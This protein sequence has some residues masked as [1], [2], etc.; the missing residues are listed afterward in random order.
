M[1]PIIIRNAAPSD[2]ASI[3]RVQ[4]DTW[5]TTYRDIVP[6]D[7]LASMSY[8]EF[9]GRW[10][11][12]LEAPEPGRFIHVAGMEDD[13]VVGF[14]SGG[15]ER[16]GDTIFTGE[17]YAIYILQEFQGKGIGRKLI[18]A[19][20][21]RLRAGAHQSMLVWVLADNPSRRFYGA[22]G[23]EEVRRKTI[24]IGGADLEE[25]AYGWRDLTAIAEER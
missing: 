8:E 18:G 6:D 25:V 23:G 5:R 10:R 22:M 16:E 21:R 7:F 24:M 3:A 9:A 12:R 14:A 20:A 17:V 4:V 15:R 13:R 1:N 19:A 11:S 2:A